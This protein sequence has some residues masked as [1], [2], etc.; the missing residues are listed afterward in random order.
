M[1]HIFKVENVKCSG[2]ANTL[3]SKL[4]D[5]FGEIDVNLELYPREIIL[6]IEPSRV[7]ELQIA[8]K[9]LGYPLSSDRLGFVDTTTTKAQSFLSCAIG[10]M[11]T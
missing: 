3:K 7:K 1:K 10:K 4:R 8:L 9:K 6:D 2:C 11:D 5:K